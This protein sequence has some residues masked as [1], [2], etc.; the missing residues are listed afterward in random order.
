[1]G[2]GEKPG[3]N[4]KLF[5]CGS[6]VFPLYYVILREEADARGEF[7]QP[8]VPY[9]SGVTPSSPC[10]VFRLEARPFFILY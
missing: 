8:P 4:F 7:G 10:L 1:M 2:N 9:P 5:S 6:L 3:K